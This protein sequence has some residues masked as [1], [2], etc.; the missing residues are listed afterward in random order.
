MVRLVAVVAVLN[1]IAGLTPPS[2]ASNGITATEASSVSLQELV[3]NVREATQ[4][5]PTFQTQH[6]DLYSNL[7]RSLDQIHYSSRGLGEIATT[8]GALVGVR[9][10][11]NDL[12]LIRSGEIEPELQF[13]KA[14]YNGVLLPKLRQS[15]AAG[16][17]SQGELDRINRP[18]SNLLALQAQDVIG[19]N[20]V[21]LRKI[22]RKYGPQSASLNFVESILNYTVIPTID[23]LTSKVF[24]LRHLTSPIVSDPIT[25]DPGPVELIAAYAPA[26]L[27][28][29]GTGA[30]SVSAVSA[31]ELG[32][33]W[34]LFREGWG[35]GDPL[36]P[37]Y[38]SAGVLISGDLQGGFRYPFKGD[39][40]LGGFFSWGAF[41]LG[42]LDEDGDRTLLL[43]KEFKVI[44]GPL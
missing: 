42:Y 4:L 29:T 43:S 1:L 5:V 40:K 26:Y 3:D 17:L 19:A 15:V 8:H 39:E 2:V 31:A 22:E 11:K 20:E 9:W 27:N 38:W 23:K 18:V 36:K 13:V 16:T 44:P 35:Q 6:P 28:P 33:R 14:V 7:D 12:R 10:S 32:I 21:F 37:A 24:L 25:G 34:Y 41:K 30:E